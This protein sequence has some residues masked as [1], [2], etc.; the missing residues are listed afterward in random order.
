MINKINKIIISVIFIISLITFSTTFNPQI[1]LSI[2]D[3]RKGTLV[4][5]ITQCPKLAPRRIPPKSVHDLR[6]D[7]IK[8]IMAIGDSVTAGFGAKGHDTNIPVDIHKLYENRGVSFPIGGDPG[9]VTIANFIK[10]YSPE[11]IGSSIGDHLIELCYGNYL[12]I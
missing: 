8:V 6:V 10:Y 1:Q 12:L 7:D 5:D 11:L 9:A 3:F 2:S 4:K